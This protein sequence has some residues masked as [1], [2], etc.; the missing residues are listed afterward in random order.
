M[1]WCRGAPT[2]WR[3]SDGQV[4]SDLRVLA[5]TKLRRWD[6]VSHPMDR[7]LLV[8]PRGGEPLRLEWVRRTELATER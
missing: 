6:V 2:P 3:G 8:L 5:E 1:L 7:L 4:Y